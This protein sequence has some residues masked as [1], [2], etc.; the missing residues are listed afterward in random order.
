MALC[1]FDG[2][3]KTL[4][5]VMIDEINIRKN[6]NVFLV[7][8]Y[9]GLTKTIIENAN[10]SQGCGLLK[11]YTSERR[12]D[13]A[14]GGV[15][16]KAISCRKQ[17]LSCVNPSTSKMITVL[18]LSYVDFP[19]KLCVFKNFMLPKMKDKLNRIHLGALLLRKLISNL[20]VH[21]TSNRRFTMPKIKFDRLQLKF[22][23]VFPQWFILL[24]AYGLIVV[25]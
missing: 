13:F 18:T 8:L 1:F 7:A 17:L 10:I 25:S 15:Q 22:F 24:L 12:V 23:C 11:R 3:L 19:F 16:I 2:T 4:I 14:C 20:A 5:V 9:Q 21:Q 6:N